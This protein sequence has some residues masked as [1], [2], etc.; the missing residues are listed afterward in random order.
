MKPSM[1]TARWFVGRWEIHR[2]AY[3]KP[4]TF[5]SMNPAECIFLAVQPQFRPD[6]EMHM[7]PEEARE[8]GTA[9]I[10]AANH[11]PCFN[12]S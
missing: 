8:L 2:T 7:T 10:E 11:N 3:D 12:P 1:V 4:S 9:L 6:R 5:Q